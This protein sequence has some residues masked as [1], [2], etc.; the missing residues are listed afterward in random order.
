MVL[1][2][3]PL[4]FLPSQEIFLFS[5]ECFIFIIMYS[6][7]LRTREGTLENAQSRCFKPIAPRVGPI[8]GQLYIDFH[9]V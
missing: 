7:A 5:W 9:N 8:H 2:R 1:V 4:D 3:T 6:E